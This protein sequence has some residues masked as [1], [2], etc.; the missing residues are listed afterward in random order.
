MD[1][2]VQ[3]HSEKTEVAFLDPQKGL[4]DFDFISC[5]EPTFLGEIYRAKVYKISVGLQAAFVRISSKLSGFLHIKNVHQAYTSEGDLKC[6]TEVLREGQDILVQVSKDP[7]K[8]KLMKLTTFITLAGKYLVLNPFNKSYQWKNDFD[9]KNPKRIQISKMIEDLV[10]KEKL[11]EQVGCLF[12]DESLIIRTSCQS[13]PR[14]DDLISDFD[15]IKRAWKQVQKLFSSNGTAEMQNS[16]LDYFEKPKTLL[17]SENSYHH[18]LVRDRITPETYR[19]IVNNAED[20]ELILKS[21]D[22]ICPKLS[23]KII[24]QKDHCLFDEFPEIGKG[25]KRACQQRVYLPSGALLFIEESEGMTCI[26][27]NSHKATASKSKNILL[28]VNL[29]AAEEVARQLILRKIGGVIKV[30]FIDLRSEEH[31]KTLMD[32]MESFLKKDPQRPALV[33]FSPL[34]ILEMTR[35]RVGPSLKE[36]LQQDCA[37]CGG[38]G[39]L[40]RPIEVFRKAMNEAFR[41]SKL[42]QQTHFKLLLRPDVFSWHKRSKWPQRMIPE[43]LSFE[44]QEA[45]YSVTGSDFHLS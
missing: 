31:Q 33:Y 6:I 42:S 22:L 10:L 37:I 2:L 20:Y 21:C 1:I 4:V 27:I 38:R 25:L 7:V 5:V 19:V 8:E 34:L 14:E 44:V 23:S 28:K 30:D 16:N 45:P 40:F 12:P 41:F 35:K 15:Y 3:R 36:S 24:F 9:S 43:G 18:T 32:A 13:E 26:D 29:E 39:S 11:F 17:W